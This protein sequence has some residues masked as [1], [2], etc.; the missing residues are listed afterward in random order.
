MVLGLTAG[1]IA[2]VIFLLAI[3]LA[4]SGFFGGLPIPFIMIIGAIAIFGVSVEYLTIIVTENI[5]VISV[6]LLIVYWWFK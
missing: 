1:Y 2:I 4:L 3:L 5:L 6:L